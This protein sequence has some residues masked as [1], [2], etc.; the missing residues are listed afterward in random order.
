MQIC[1]FSAEKN[2]RRL[3]NKHPITANTIVE[4]S[5]PRGIRSIEISRSVSQPAGRTP[6]KG[7]TFAKVVP[8]K[9]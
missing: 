8:G 1:C 4:I 5:T 3:E 7:A 9:E 6:G 2:R